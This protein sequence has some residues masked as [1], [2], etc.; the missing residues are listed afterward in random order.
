[1]KHWT[2]FFLVFTLYTFSLKAERKEQVIYDRIE[3]IYNLKSMINESVWK[4]VA[5]KKYDLPLVYYT[6]TACYIANPTEKFINSYKPRRVFKNKGIMICKT[7]LLDSI[8]FH[9]STNITLGDSTSDYD[10]RAPFMNAS[11]FEITRNTIPDVNSTEQWATMI[12]H[13]YF[14]GFQYKH[15]GYLECFEKN[16]VSIHEDSLKR[17][18]KSNTW[19]K[20]SIDKENDALL[21]AINSTDDKEIKQ[22]I[23]TFFQLREQRRLVTKQQLHFE[24]RTTEEV[25]ETMEGTARYV[26]YSLYNKFATMHP[27]YKLIK[28]DSSYHSY[29]YFKNYKIENDQWLFKT[30]KTTY[31][32]AIGFNIAR[33]LDKLKIEYKS[34]LFNESGLS[35][36]Q[37]LKTY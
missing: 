28:S 26:E 11:S 35:L 16:V 15:P 14:H 34:R 4:D 10:Y 21:S 1:M 3:Y 8:P 29:N 37:I 27:D 30:S 22:L 12:I 24:I 6:D 33:L 13:E 5:D 36:E 31:F 19:F 23:K 20:E 17:I 32:Y 7:P 18:Y 25:Y 9:M 2:L